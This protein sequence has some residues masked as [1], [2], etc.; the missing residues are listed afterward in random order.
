MGTDAGQRPDPRIGDLHVL[1]HAVRRR[2]TAVLAGTR[3][4]VMLTLVGLLVWTL[5]ATATATGGYRHGAPDEP[6]VIDLRLT[7]TGSDDTAF[8]VASFNVLGHSHTTGSKSAYADGVTRMGYAFEILRNHHVNVVGFQ[9]LQ[10]PQL[11]KFNELTGKRWAVYPGGRLEN[12]A[13]H[14][15]IAWKTRRWE[16]VSADY[17]NIPYFFGR[18]VKM[19]VVKLR[20]VKTGRLVYFANFH[21]PADSHGDAQKWRDQARRKQIALANRIAETGIPLV[22]T[23]DMNEREKYF[24]NM[25]ARAPMRAAN[26]GSNRE[27]EPCDTPPYMGIDWIFGSRA[28]SFEDYRRVVTPLV[29]KTTDHPFLVTRA[30]IPNR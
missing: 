26:G 29:D 6:P 16:K 8:H 10:P 12:I 15:S 28:V 25:V 5:L 30:I 27:G 24:C 2:A 3:S 7:A 4:W 18:L 22:L 17:I 20:H 13:M 21:N 9:E 19:P 14:N 11:E 23:G 1:A